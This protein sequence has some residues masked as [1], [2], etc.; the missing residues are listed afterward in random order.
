MKL[1][2]KIIL[3]IVVIIASFCKVKQAV[4]SDDCQLSEVNKFMTD[5]IISRDTTLLGNAHDCLNSNKEFLQSGITKENYSLVFSVLMYSRKYGELEVLLKHSDFQ[6]DGIDLTLNMIKA[7]K[8]YNQNNSEAYEYIYKNLETIR[9]RIEAT[10]RD[11]TLYS[12][13][14][15]MQLY[16]NGREKCHNQLDSL[17]SANKTFTELFYEQILRDLI[18]EYPKEYLFPE[19]N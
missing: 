5:F 2:L 7:L 13:Y 3:I 16:L 10:P 9:E 8:V 11:S 19:E 17:K 18:N 14:F 6:P 12:Q 15:V 1:S 4:S